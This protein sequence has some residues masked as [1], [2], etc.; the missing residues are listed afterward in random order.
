MLPKLVNKNTEKKSRKQYFLVHTENQSL[1]KQQKT[2]AVQVE[3]KI[4]TILIKARKKKSF[5]FR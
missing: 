2:A 1:L 4:P 3:L 5:F